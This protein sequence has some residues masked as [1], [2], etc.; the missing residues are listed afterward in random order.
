MK[1]ISF[2]RIH[3]IFMK[4]LWEFSRN[5]A[6]SLM[7]LMPI[8]FAIMYKQMMDSKIGLSLVIVSIALGLLTT[9]IQA[10]F[11]AE[12]K[13]KNT[14]RNLLLSPASLLDILIGKSLL[15]LV[16]TVV[17]LAVSFYI[18]NFM[19]GGL[20]IIALIL[21]ILIYCA[22]GTIS[23]LFAN[24][25]LE[26]TYTILPVTFIFAF[27]PFIYAL[28]EKFAIL[29]IFKW[30]PSTQ[31]AEIAIE[32][33]IVLGFIVIVVWLIMSWAIALMLCKRRMVD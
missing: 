12:E 14:L 16:I 23:G 4:D 9:F 22:L 31:F 28:R 18:L 5:Y 20:Y 29:E 21:N 33:D 11:I 17:A 10:S 7:I 30:L 32:E 26:T 13:E 24:S 15:V 2:S 27:S 6:V 3:A 25:T 1:Q 19:P 8:V